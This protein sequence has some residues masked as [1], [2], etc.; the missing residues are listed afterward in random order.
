[1][2]AQSLP[3][4]PPAPKVHAKDLPGWRLLLEFSR[5]TVSTLP[6]YAF[7]ALISR[8][9]VLGFDS[10]LLNDPDGV[11]H[12]LTTAM[13]K[14]K[15][16][17]STHRVLAPLGGNGLFLAAGS[18][19]RRQRRALAPV[20]SPADV[21]ILLPHLWRPRRVWPTRS[22]VRR[23]P[24]WLW[25]SKRQ[26]SRPSCE[27]SSP[28]RT[29]IS[30]GASPQWS[31]IIFRGRAVPISSMALREPNNRSRLLPDGDA[32]SCR[33]GLIRSTLSSQ[34]G[35]VR[36]HQRRIAIYSIFS[37]P[38]EIRSPEEY[39]RVSTVV[40]NVRRCSSLDTKPPRDSF[41]GRLMSSR[42]T[43]PSRI[44]C[45]MNSQPIHRSESA[46]SMTFS[47]GR[48]YAIRC[49]KPCASIHPSHILPVRQL[50]MTS[51]RVSAVCQDRKCG[52]ALGSFIVIVSSGIVL[53]HSSRIVSRASLRHGQA[54]ARSYH[55]GRARGSASV[56]RL[57]WP[58][59][60][61]CWRCCCHASRSRSMT[62]A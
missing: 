30:V 62:R 24:I 16:L 2:L 42:S 11:R 46:S 49:S 34:A 7:D 18:Q 1:M 3:I 26:H 51:F 48:D 19:C 15:R 5:N 50:L 52:S 54:A 35:K 28:S 29:A 55:L 47:I 40:T 10:L 9:R 32:A 36:Q 33:L 37:L 59:P 25:R 17:V 53:P 31:G 60:R 4:I 38:P 23:V 57:P 58:K 61:S 20:F 22:I 27:H 8:R 14:Y 44:V 43:P 6:D 21:G 41:S 39:L 56:R 45:A 12:V 13:E